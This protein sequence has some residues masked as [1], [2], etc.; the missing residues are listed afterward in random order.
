MSNIVLVGDKKY[1]KASLTIDLHSTDKPLSSF[2]FHIQKSF[3][4]L[5]NLDIFDKKN[6]TLNSDLTFLQG[7]FVT[8][9]I[10]RNRDVF[11]PSEML[12]SFTTARLKPI[13]VE[14][15]VAENESFVKIL[16][17]NASFPIFSGGNTIIGTI[18][19]VAFVH[20]VS[21]KTI[22]ASE[23]LSQDTEETL[24][25]LAEIDKDFLL[26]E[27]RYHIIIAAVLWKFMFP[28]TIADIV[29]DIDAGKRALSM[30]CYFEDWDWLVD[31]KIYSRRDFPG[32]DE[33]YYAGKKNVCRVLRNILWGAGGL[34]NYPAN[35][36]G[37]DFIQISNNVEDG[38]RILASCASLIEKKE[39]EKINQR[40]GDDFSKTS[41]GEYQMEI[42]EL[43]EVNASLAKENA[44]LAAS[45]QTSVAKIASLEKEIRDLETKVSANE[46]SA[47]EAKNEITEITKKAQTDLEAKASLEKSY[48]ELKDVFEKTKA[49]LDEIKTAKEV[50]EQK[51]LS[52]EKDSK[53]LLEIKRQ[54]TVATRKEKL[55]FIKA[56]LDT[57]TDEA[58]ASLED[59]E[60]DILLENREKIAKAAI[61]QSK[62]EDS[63]L[64]AILP[65]GHD[66]AVAMRAVASSNSKN[67]NAFNALVDL[68]QKV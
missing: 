59:K 44:T 16:E 56:L 37:L 20:D 4:D 15:Y 50:L 27:N 66:N 18:Y 34:V 67:G 65:T 5:Q 61:A 30:E 39:E 51:A 45:F 54:Q 31:D 24:M 63:T 10:N 12:R 52:F 3:A 35:P 38:I 57:D 25:Q 6:F 53:E 32:I 23:F 7:I 11:L 17:Q 48:T 22:L 28:R 40:G 21:G 41:Q 43:V 42:K 49:E 29:E 14:H 26:R 1:H 8:S 55:Q 2:G 64:R 68:M 58:I 9:G 36:Y 62:D 46:Q 13:N 60:F 19:D 33:D 47:I